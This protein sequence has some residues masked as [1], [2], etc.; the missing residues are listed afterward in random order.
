MESLQVE[1]VE[2]ELVLTVTLAE[3]EAVE[4]TVKPHQQHF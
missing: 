1:Q 3:A 4:V 2:E